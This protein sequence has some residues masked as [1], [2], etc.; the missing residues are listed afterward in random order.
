MH[1]DEE[2][3]TQQTERGA[4]GADRVEMTPSRFLLAF[5]LPFVI[6]GVLT[7]LIP[8]AAMFGWVLASWVGFYFLTKGC[9]TR[10]QGIVALVYFPFMIVVMVIAAFLAPGFGI[11]IHGE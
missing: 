5:G 1:Y 8:E 4:E 6:D 10:T 3:D 2:D 9:T 7:Q 11:P